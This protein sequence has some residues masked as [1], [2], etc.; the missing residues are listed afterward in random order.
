MKSRKQMKSLQNNH[1]DEDDDNDDGRDDDWRRRR[2]K[3]KGRRTR[4]RGRRRGKREGEEEKERKRETLSFSLF[5]RWDYQG[6]ER[7]LHVQ[8]QV[9]LPLHS[10]NKWCPVLSFHTLQISFWASNGS[11]LSSPEVLSFCSPELGL[12]ISL[13]VS[14][15]RSG[16]TC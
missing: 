11:W 10:L 6:P 14:M 15:P 3:R 12:L 4:R 1:K 5:H 7:L 9:F 8:S 16:E 2:R 13:S